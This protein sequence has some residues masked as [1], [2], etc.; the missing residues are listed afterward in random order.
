M[1]T[2]VEKKNNEIVCKRQA[3]WEEEAENI[4]LVNIYSLNY[5]FNWQEHVYCV[6][7]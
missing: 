5:I 6:Q 4:V 3:E 1:E 7:V 2:N